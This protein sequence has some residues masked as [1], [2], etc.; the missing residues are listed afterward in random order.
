MPGGCFNDQTRESGQLVSG[1]AFVR[2]DKH[3]GCRLSELGRG[4]PDGQA[5]NGRQL[6][7]RN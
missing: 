1:E 4:E 2:F 5:L 7:R 6:T 3:E